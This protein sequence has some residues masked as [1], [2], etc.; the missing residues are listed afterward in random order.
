MEKYKG[1]PQI[2]PLSAV[3]IFLFSEEKRRSF[4]EAAGG[5]NCESLPDNLRHKSLEWNDNQSKALY[6]LYV[7]YLFSHQKPQSRDKL[8]LRFRRS[9]LMMDS[10]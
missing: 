9:L 10:Q 3:G 6:S 8:L 1:I 5:N 2:K 4:P 7:M